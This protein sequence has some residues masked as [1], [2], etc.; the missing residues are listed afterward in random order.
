MLALVTLLL[1]PLGVIGIQLALDL[2][3]AWGV[4]G[5][6]LQGERLVLVAEDAEKAQGIPRESA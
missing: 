1:L 5:Y 6:S 3:R 4:A 2:D